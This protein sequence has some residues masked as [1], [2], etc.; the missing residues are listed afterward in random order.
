VTE[1]EL[2]DAIMDCFTNGHRNPEHC[3]HTSVVDTP[4]ARLN[5]VQIAMWERNGAWW[6]NQPGYSFTIGGIT[7][8]MTAEMVLCDTHVKLAK[9]VWGE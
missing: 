5:P 3:Y 6:F 2:I 4:G 7:V 8:P 9:Q 1:N